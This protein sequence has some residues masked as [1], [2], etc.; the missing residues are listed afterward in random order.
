MLRNDTCDTKMSQDVASS[1][2]RQAFL[3]TSLSSPRAAGNF[4]IVNFDQCIRET[5]C[6]LR[7]LSKN[8]VVQPL[9][10]SK[11]SSIPSS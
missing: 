4:L 2:L 1:V 10:S 11:F 6:R 8:P 9:I 7:I 3:E 5:G